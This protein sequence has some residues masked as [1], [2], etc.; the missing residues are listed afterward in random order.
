MTKEELE[1]KLA[2]LEAKLE[3]EN[4]QVVDPTIKAKAESMLNFSIMDVKIA[5]DVLGIEPSVDEQIAIEE[6]IIASKIEGMSA[7]A[8]RQTKAKW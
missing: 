4:H 5:L 1:A 7:K 2:V 3:E 8:G 6:A